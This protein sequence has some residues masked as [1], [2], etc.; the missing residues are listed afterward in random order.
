M[1][2]E[3]LRGIR[4]SERFEVIAAVTMKNAVFRGIKI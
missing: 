4:D 3:T 2:I 1:C